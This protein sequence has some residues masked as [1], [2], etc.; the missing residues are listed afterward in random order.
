V[1]ALLAVALTALLVPL[2]WNRAVP[3]SATLVDYLI[4]AVSELLIGL[5]LGLGVVILFAGVQMAG[6][7]IAQA[8]GLQLA[9]VFNPAL[10]TSLPVV[11]QFLY[12]V[13]LALF[14]LLGGHRL[15]L[16]G[17]LETLVHL[18][19][20]ASVSRSLVDTLSALVSQ[21][22]ALGVRAAAPTLA[23]LLLATLVLGLVGRTLPQL[24]VMALGFGASAVVTLLVLAASLGS[25]LWI[26]QEQVEPLI[27]QISGAWHG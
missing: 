20:G 3:S 19:P 25:A 4:L 14:V 6:Q 15:V 8:S 10:E 13:A 27:D 11:S 23:A 7:I 22:F 21:S 12:L 5:T 17:L 1:R 18:P 2:T 26:F 16:E 24:N 9:D